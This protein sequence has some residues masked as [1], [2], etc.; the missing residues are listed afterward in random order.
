[1]LSSKPETKSSTLPA[2][3]GF[4]KVTFV[5]SASEGHGVFS[6]HEGSP[7]SKEVMEQLGLIPNPAAA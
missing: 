6:I 1:M 7:A 4:P 3:L 5:L 2:R